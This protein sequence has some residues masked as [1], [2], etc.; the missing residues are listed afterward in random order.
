MDRK[1]VLVIGVGSGIGREPALRFA[2][3]FVKRFVM[4]SPAMPNLKSNRA[5]D[6]L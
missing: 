4:A 3:R 1:S 2:K 5:R 6:Y